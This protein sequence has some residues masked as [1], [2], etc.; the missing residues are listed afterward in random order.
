MDNFN[1]LQWPAMVVTLLA[2]WL[3]ASASE[4]KRRWGF[5]VLCADHSPNRF[6]GD[7]YQGGH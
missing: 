1:L 5:W 7:E 3:V 4:K 6:D 2:S